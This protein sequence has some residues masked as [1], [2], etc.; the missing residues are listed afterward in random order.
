MERYK[1]YRE[2]GD[3]AITKRTAYRYKERSPGTNTRVEVS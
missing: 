3:E 2:E 1:K